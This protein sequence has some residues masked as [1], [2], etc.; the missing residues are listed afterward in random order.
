MFRRWKLKSER[1]LGAGD[2][3]CSAHLAHDREPCRRERAPRYSDADGLNAHAK[4]GGD[5]PLPQVG[6]NFSSGFHAAIFNNFLFCATRHFV[7][8]F[9]VHIWRIKQP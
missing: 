4:R 6:D 1:A 7:D 9:K 5:G 8:C 2:A 3:F